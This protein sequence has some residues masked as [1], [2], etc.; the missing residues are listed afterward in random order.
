MLSVVNVT[1]LALAL[2]FRNTLVILT[3]AV[4]LNVFKILIAIEQRL[5]SIISVKI[6]ALAY[7]ALMLNVV[8]LTMHRHVIALMAIQEI[9]I[10][11]VQS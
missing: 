11:L 7:A 2:V 8:S 1:V 5:A 3:V 10:N 9:L 6:H 4:G